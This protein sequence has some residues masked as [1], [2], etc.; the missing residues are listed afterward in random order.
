M[1][2]KKSELAADEALLKEKCEDCGGDRTRKQDCETC[3]GV[4]FKL[5]GRERRAALQRVRVAKAAVAELER[6]LRTT[7]AAVQV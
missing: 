5:C 2:K 3:F 6:R 7:A 4:G 1:D